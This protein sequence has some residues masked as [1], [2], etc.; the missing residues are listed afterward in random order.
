MGGRGHQQGLAGLEGG[1]EGHQQEL[2][3]LEGG[4]EGHQQ[5]LGSCGWGVSGTCR[6]EGCGLGVRGMDL[7][8]GKPRGQGRL[9]FSTIKSKSNTKMFRFLQFILL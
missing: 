6:A 2:A 7:C 1:N 5:G 8:P 3:G 9:L 4:N